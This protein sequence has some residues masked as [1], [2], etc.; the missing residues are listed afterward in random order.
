MDNCRATVTNSIEVVWC[1]YSRRQRRNAWLNRAMFGND[2]SADLPTIRVY[3]LEWAVEVELAARRNCYVRSQALGAQY[4]QHCISTIESNASMGVDTRRAEGTR[5]HGP[6]S[7]CAEPRYDHYD[8]T[9]RD[10]LLVVSPVMT[11]IYEQR[12]LASD[13][14]LLQMIYSE[15]RLCCQ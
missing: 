11:T 6:G 1:E 12:C 10:S 4:R 15:Q 13:V 7:R 9:Q 8:A 2:D 5:L 14:E 3:R